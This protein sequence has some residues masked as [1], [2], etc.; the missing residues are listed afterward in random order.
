MAVKKITKIETSKHILVPK[1][2]KLSEKDKKS[3]LEKYNISV[4][5]LPSIRSTDAGIASLDVEVGDVIKI[6]RDSP[7]AGTTVFYRGVIDG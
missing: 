5:Q 1:M 6:E 4:N 3:L 2:K 7:T